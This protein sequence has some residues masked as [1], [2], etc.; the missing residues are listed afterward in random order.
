M[1][2]ECFQFPKL[3]FFLF[4]SFA[5]YLATEKQNNSDASGAK[6]RLASLVYP[7]LVSWPTQE[8]QEWPTVK[9]IPTLAHNSR[10]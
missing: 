7:P 1:S 9:G 8:S 5:C 4:Y 2:P 6:P 3:F 10:T